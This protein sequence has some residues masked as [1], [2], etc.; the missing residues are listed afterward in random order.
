MES[1]E[2]N[3]TDFAEF[4]EEQPSI[5]RKKEVVEYTIDGIFKTIYSSIAA[6]NRITGISASH[7]GNICNGRYPYYKGDLKN[8]EPR[9]FLFRDGDICERL[10]VISKMSDLEKALSTHAIS[11]KGVDVYSLT[12]KLLKHYPTVALASQYCSITQGMITKCCKG[13]K[14]YIEDKIFLY[15]NDGSIKDRVKKVK[16][17]LWELSQKRH[18][19]IE[20]NAYTINGEFIRG[21]ISA[22]AAARHF[23]IPVSSISRCCKGLPIK[24]KNRSNPHHSLYTHNMIF[25]KVG[26]SISNRLEE[27]KQHKDDIKRKRKYK[28]I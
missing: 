21:F 7:I 14:V 2:L 13:K 1:V 19:E 10:N 27:I 3:L 8:I 25:L 17:I 23:N 22:S 24:V 28:T 5:D 11:N 4:K 16:R 15:T 18:R 9:I 20:V 12:G 6:A 26:D